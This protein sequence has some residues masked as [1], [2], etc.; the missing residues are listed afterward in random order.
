MSKK[1]DAGEA[2]NDALSLLKSRKDALLPVVAALVFLPNLAFE[3]LAGQPD[4]AGLTS[5]DQIIK[6]MNQYWADNWLTALLSM[7][8][9]LIG[10]LS[11]YMIFNRKE[12]VSIGEVITAALKLAPLYL[13]ASI[14]LGIMLGLS[15][16]LLIIPALYLFA[17]FSP[18]GAVATAET[19]LGIG[20]WFSRT[21]NVTKDNGWRIFLYLFIIVVVGFVLMMVF[22]GVFGAVANMLGGFSIVKAAV[23]SLSSAVLTVVM[24]AAISSIYRQLGDN[25]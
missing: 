14:L 21:W 15:A 20:G 13:V 18:L 3:T 16:L 10:G 5:I 8:V 1:F 11:V 7:V 24:S 19:E 25:T 6:V 12:G 23:T 4:I 2:W 17:R 22:N 9:G